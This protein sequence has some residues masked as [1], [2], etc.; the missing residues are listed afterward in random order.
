[1]K[2]TER[3]SN[4]VE[5]YVRYR[6]GY[7]PEVFSFLTGE[8]H[9]KPSWMIAD[10]GSGTGILSEIFLRNGNTVFGVE[11]NNEMRI[12]AEK[13]LHHYS[14]FKSVN[15]T[16]E[17]TTLPPH[18]VD[19]VTAG[20]AFHW[21]DQEKTKKEFRR[22]GK[23]GGPVVLLWN[24]RRTDTS[25]FLKAY[26]ELLLRY[27]SDYEQ[28]D[29]RHVNET[30]LSKFFTSHIKK[31]FSNSQRFDFEGLKGR[32]LSSSYVPLSDDKRFVPM[33]RELKNIFDR[34]QQNGVVTFEYGT[35]VY[36]GTLD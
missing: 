13:L 3:F 11:P 5:N 7:P 1:M 14:N 10:V 12:A 34:T 16:A 22:I 36:A 17:A 31:V 28:I 21:F 6:P 24:T 27:S 2:S 15:G 8:L 9:L 30:V 32:L 33:M 4:R 18:G 26:E 35:E 19:L 20:Q 25:P 23:R 29:H